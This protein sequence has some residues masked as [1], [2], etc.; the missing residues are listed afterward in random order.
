V[1]TDGYGSADNGSVV[2]HLESP[3]AER[4][5]VNSGNQSMPL[6]YDNRGPSS[7]SEAYR[8]LEAEQSDWLA[9]DAEAL[10]LHFHGSTAKDHN[11]ETDRLYVV[12]EDDRNGSAVVY[13]PRPEALLSDGW[14]EWTIG[15]DEFG[16]VDLRHVKRLTLGVGDRSNPQPGGDSVVYIDDIGLTSGATQSNVEE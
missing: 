5:I 11:I 10:T 2:G 14:Q 1:W 16:D 6:F 13:H 3:F 15:F 12:V 8:D 7:Y 4:V 9:Y